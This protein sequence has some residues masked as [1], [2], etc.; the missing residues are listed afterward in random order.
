LDKVRFL[1]ESSGRKPLLVILVSLLLLTTSA[2]SDVAPSQPSEANKAKVVRQVAQRW[3][4]VGAEQY[5]RGYFKAAKQSFLRAQ[6]Y[7]EYLTADEREKLTALLEKTHKGIVEREYILETIRTADGLV[8][9]SE[10]SKAKAKLEEVKDS[11]FLTEAERELITKG[12]NKLGDQSDEKKKEITELYNRSVEFY[13]AGQLEK[14]REGF[15]KVATRSD[16]VAAPPGE[17]AEDYLLKID[18]VLAQ[19]AEPSKP[20][21][22]KPEDELGATIAAITKELLGGEAEP[23]EVAEQQVG[24]EPNE[25]VVAAVPEGEATEAAASKDTY[26]EVINRKRSIRQSHTRAVVNDA[27]AK[28]Q[29]YISQDEF[30]KAKE[31]VERAERIVNEY[32]LD[33]GDELFRQHSGEL[34]QLAEKIVQEQDKRVQQLQ[35][36][37]RLEAIEAQRRDRKQMEVDRSKRIAEL[38]DNAVTFQ[39]Q[40]RY[41]DALGQ[42]ESLLTL[43]PLNNQALILKQTLEDMVGFRKQLEVQR[44]T[45]KERVDTLIGADQAMIPYADELRYPK[46]WRDIIARRQPTP[47]IGKSPAD[48]VVEKQLNEIVDLTQLTP[49]TPF[50]EAIEMLKHSVT[51]PLQI[52]VNWR[53]LSDNADIDQT[54]PIHMDPI[55]GIPLKRA[56]ELLLEA[57]SGGFANIQKS[58]KDGV[59]TIATAASLQPVL[60]THVYDVTDLIGQPADF[61]TQAGG[62]VTIPAVGEAGTEQLGEQEQISRDQLVTEATARLAALVQLIQQTISPTSWVEAGG[63]ASITVYQNKKLVIYQTSEVHNQIEKMLDDLREALGNQVAIEARFLVVGENFLEDIGLDVDRIRIPAGTIGN[64]VG[65]I[66]FRQNSSDFTLPSDT[67]ITGS[68]GPTVNP[69]GGVTGISAI[70][71]S[72]IIGNLAM[73]NQLQVDLILRATQAHRDAKSLTAP[74]VTVLSGERAS[75]QVRRIRRYPYDI[76]IDVTQIGTTANYMYTVGTTQGFIASGPLLNITPTITPDKKNVLLTIDAQLANF[77]DWQFYTIQLPAIGGGL[78]QTYTIQ[79]PETEQSRVQTRVSVPDRAT[80]L[81]GGQRVTA[82]IE[83]EAGVPVLSKVPFL[84]RLFSNRSKVKDSQILLILVK[85]T[86]ILREE[87]EHKAIAELESS[88]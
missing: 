88:L 49:E 20:T 73:L 4:E 41:E 45:E 58:L 77:L 33:L 82:D 65:L 61:Y 48:A 6:D 51:P 63:E 23:N 2:L 86:I 5:K 13:N 84:G 26:I 71:G 28:V 32:Q 17:T 72:A 39:S 46:D 38:M 30:D 54:T 79:Y 12:L 80:L 8:K 53:D 29:N 24:Q 18:N 76:T 22:A 16:L 60:V 55:S 27:V 62:T 83:K 81:L 43:D 78:G 64:R 69:G 47:P 35:E 1:I 34:K 87:A 52:F 59:I 19:K 67:G 75:F 21:E 42:I 3:I 66:D 74:K 68:F 31:E 7:Q 36:Q 85:P 10:L 40:Q 9:Q 57:V 25:L 56:L 15:V 44:E 14:A 11:E 37:K 50:G 70:T